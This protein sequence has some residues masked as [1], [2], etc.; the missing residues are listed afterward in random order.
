MHKFL[1]F[2]N[3]AKRTDFPV[4]PWFI[5]ICEVNCLSCVIQISRST[6]RIYLN[7][8]YFNLFVGL[9]KSVILLFWLVLLIVF[10]QSPKQLYFFL[11]WHFKYLCLPTLF[12]LV[13]FPVFI[14]FMCLMVPKF[15]SLAKS[16]KSR[17]LQGC[18]GFKK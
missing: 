8:S 13:H 15:I 17:L 10:S 3:S 16:N 14:A 6:A 2:H 4:C 7:P 11:C 1:F 5:V 18:I 12:S 9:V